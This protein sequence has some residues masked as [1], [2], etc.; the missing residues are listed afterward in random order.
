MPPKIEDKPPE[1]TVADYAAR[2]EAVMNTVVDGIITIDSGGS[3]KSFNPS[4]ERIFGFS[5]DEVI[6]HNVKMLMPEPY[7]GEHDGYI[8]NYLDTGHSSIIGVGRRVEAK[9]KDGSVF[10]ME[11]GV[12]EMLISGQRMFVGTIRDVTDRKK[13]EDEV[14]RSNEELERFAYVASHDLQEPLRMV[15][16]FTALLNDEYGKDMDEQ[17]G[18]YMRFIVDAA[19][20]MQALVSDLLEYSRVDNE[21]GG[22]TNVNCVESVEL[23]I[24]NLHDVIEETGAKI[25][26]GDL[27][28]IFVNPVRFSRLMQNLIGNAIKYRKKNV[29]PEITIQAKEAEDSWLFSLAD[30]GI[31]MKEEYLEAIFN[32]FKRLHSKQDYQG[33]GIGLSICKRIVQ[34]FDGEIW[35]TSH[36]GE[37]STFYFTVPKR[38]IAEEAA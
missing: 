20:R 31:G 9:R 5:E 14:M 22:F 1:E 16:N 19:G 34:S 36:P 10:P 12:S 2:L 13:A 15:V 25:S 3:I 29:P 27:P 7:H 6:G 8:R 24:S 11:L 28:V 4:A 21:E 37:G 23:A 38:Q 35:V 32:I 18:Q 17:A 30:N 33:T 26:I